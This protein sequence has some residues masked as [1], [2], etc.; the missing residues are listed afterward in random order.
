MIRNYFKL[1]DT[2]TKELYVPEDKAKELIIAIYESAEEKMMRKNPG[3]AAVIYE[4][5]QQQ[6]YTRDRRAIRYLAF[7]YFSLVTLIIASCLIFL[8]KGQTR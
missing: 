1:Y 5:Q 8:I 7:F 3:I 6:R 2:L 4:E